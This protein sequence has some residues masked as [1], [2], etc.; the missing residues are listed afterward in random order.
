MRFWA[1][2][3]LVFALLGSKTASACATCAAGDP[4]MN[5]SGS[6]KPFA[7]RRRVSL[8]ARATSARAADVQIWEQRLELRAD[9]AVSST[10]LVGASLPAIHRTI[11]NQDGASSRELTLGDA[12]ARASSTIYDSGIARW[13]RS[14]L[15]F[16]GSKFPT[17]PLQTDAHGTPL[18]VALQPGCGSLVPELGASFVAT[19]APLTFVASTLFYL[20]FSVRDGPHAGDS[21]RTSLTLQVQPAHSKI[22]TRFGVTAR[23]DQA[24]LSNE[25][26]TDPNSGGFVGTVSGEILLMPLE[27]VVAGVGFFA[28]ALQALRGSQHEGAI[29][30][31]TFS[32]DF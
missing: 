11:E 29:G 20:P 19:H 8:D 5:A 6:E 18:P 30:L 26:D 28:P 12:E 3:A 16:G 14:V 24:G 17:A 21:W 13:R 9:I 7:S 27:D 1:F 4:T 32:Y 15:V 2:F 22:A 10:V 25:Q 31:M 23:L